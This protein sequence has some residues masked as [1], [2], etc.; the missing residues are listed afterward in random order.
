MLK[1]LLVASSFLF[2]AQIG[3]M[4][5]ASAQAYMRGKIRN[6]IKTDIR[7]DQEKK[8]QEKGR[9]E[10]KKITYE[11]DTRY[12]DAKNRVNATI[13][14]QM[15][16]FDKKGV[17]KKDV[18]R[19]K[20][21]FGQNGECFVLNEGT[22]DEMWL[23]FDYSKKANYMV[24]VSQKTATKMPLINVK[25]MVERMAK[26]ESLE[27]SESGEWK[28]TNEKQKINGFNCVKHIYTDKDGSK[29]DVWVSKDIQ[30][31]LSDNYILGAKIKDYGKGQS[32]AINPNH[33]NGLMVRNV[34][35]DK[36][37]GQPSS[38]SDLLSFK[39]SSEAKYFD[40]S[41]F[42][43]SDVLGGF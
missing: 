29:M 28:L 21:V 24:N 23:L 15:K 8:Q 42:K 39:K 5:S 36:K 10:L 35:Y 3:L 34:I 40:L 19:S 26:N 37:S 9:E 1:R 2:V 6:Q 31:D 32:Q 17:E 7:K 22:K 33:P 11:N 25:K 27:E 14:M 12:E 38:Q 4:S 18:V 13:E 20:L 16:S 43:V 41:S 30:L